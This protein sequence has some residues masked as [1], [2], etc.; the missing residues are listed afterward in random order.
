MVATLIERSDPAVVK[1]E[2]VT[3]DRPGPIARRLSL[4]GIRVRSLGGRGTVVSF[5][6]LAWILAGKRF[7]V[8]NAYGFKASVVTRTLAWGL[9]H[10]ATFICGV[11]GL[12]V[13]AVEDLS[14]P[15][16]RFVLLVERL[17]SPLVD[18]Y[19]AN[20]RGALALL[21]SVGIPARKL[22]YIPNGIDLTRWPRVRRRGNPRPTVLCVGRFAVNKRQ[23]DLLAAGR[24]LTQDDV[25]FRLMFVGDGPM[26]KDVQHAA[27]NLDGY[28]RF[29]GE[30]VGT[31]LQQLY[32]E[33]DVFC[34]PSIWE[35]MAVSVMEAMAAALP[36]V[37]TNVNGISDLV[38]DGETGFVVQP[39]RPRELANA[40]GRLLA[41]H[42]LRTRLGAA[43]RKRIETEFTIE[44]MVA[45][46]QKLYRRAA[47]AM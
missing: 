31:E 20:S 21:T 45:A 4:C 11:R 44:Q 29:C 5:A 17:L 28:V 35:G 9:C 26:L 18:T 8:I 41:D 32:Q 15:K 38:L 16:S 1:L 22:V 39:R 13:T 10:S 2:L 12:H 6:R 36:V 47:A 3:L 23:S 25:A 30:V 33:A 19:D 14:G 34:L 40:L 43:G 37:G 27:G 24:L 7:D 46:K 42:D